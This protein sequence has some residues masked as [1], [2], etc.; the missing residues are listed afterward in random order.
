MRKIGLLGGSFNPAHDGHVHISL[1]AIKRLHL[2]EVWWILSPHNPLKDQK[3]LAP[4][5]E[6]KASALDAIAAHKQ[7]KLSEVEHER[8]LT[9]TRDT[10]RYL[11]THRHD[12]QFVW[13]M[14][15]DNLAVFHKWRGWREIARMLPFVVMDR[16]PHFYQAQRSKAAYAL[17]KYEV[18][19]SHAPLLPGSTPPAWC[20]IPIRTHPASSTE[21]RKNA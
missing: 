18:P 4:Y 2:H 5:E 14:G 10:L 9:Y 21:I 8:G 13:L 7:I 19:D 11:T 15:A 3:D 17:A 6:R 16:S 20:Y 1:E 12:A